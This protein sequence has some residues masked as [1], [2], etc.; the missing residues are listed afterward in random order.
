MP[1]QRPSR[2]LLRNI[3]LKFVSDKSGGGGAKPVDSQL[4][5]VPIID[6]MICM[7]VFLLMSFNASG[8]L[9]AQKPSIKLP[10]AANGDVLESGPTLAVDSAVVTLD[11][12]RIADTSTLAADARVER[13]EPLIQRLETMRRN[14]AILHP[15]KDFPG[16][17]LVQADESIDYR[18][19]KKLMFSAA[20]AGYGNVRFAVNRSA[21]TQ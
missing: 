15:N 16:E 1:I 10:S 13:I 5:L 2:V 18:V 7:V 19:I 17:I 21:H 8:E 4:P 14:Y 11:E 20:Q 3:P 6:L 9:V 12:Q